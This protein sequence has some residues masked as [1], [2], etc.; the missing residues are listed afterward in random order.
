M[1]KQV[2][3]GKRS[4]LF[5]VLPENLLIVGLDDGP[6]GE[7]HPL[8]AQHRV[9]LD[10]D[11]AMRASIEEFGVLEPVLCRKTDDHIEVLN[12]R[13]RVKAARAVNKKRPPADRIRI[14]IRIIKAKDADTAMM[15][16]VMTDELRQDDSTLQRAQKSAR[17]KRV[18][19][20]SDEETATAFGVSVQTVKVWQLLLRLP[21]TMQAAV[22]SGTVGAVAASKLAT[23][24]DPEQQS[25]A[26]TAL[27]AEGGSAPEA[28][29]Q[30]R[31]LKAAAQGADPTDV[32]RPVSRTWVRKLVEAKPEEVKGLDPAALQMLRWQLGMIGPK[33][34]PG[35]MAA[36]RA[37]GLGGGE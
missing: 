31:K 29:A 25:A 12:G 35:L 7:E 20:K 36:L 3:D 28:A 1:G 15:V 8:F 4:S 9:E 5:D 30:V 21:D 10:V 26:W 19:G 2:V 34:V 11:Q 18:L 24:K 16:M 22:E 13:Q 23:I 32:R 14:P 6:V 37:L 33:K 27:L 17:L